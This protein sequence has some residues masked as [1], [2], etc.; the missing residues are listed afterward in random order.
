LCGLLG[1]AL[2]GAYVL[3]VNPQNRNCLRQIRAKTAALERTKNE[4][5]LL[6][7]GDSCVAFGLDP[8]IL[9]E[10]TG[11][12]TIN[13]GFVAGD[14]ALALLGV[15]DQAAHTGD[16]LV[17]SLLPGLLDSNVH[18]EREGRLLA[19]LYGQPSIALGGNPPLRPFGVTEHLLTYL[20]ASVPGARLLVNDASRFALHLPG[21]RYEKCE[22]DEWGYYT[23]KVILPHDP[24]YDEIVPPSPEW[25]AVLRQFVDRMQAR[26]VRVY[27]SMPWHECTA[28]RAA[29]VRRETAAFLTQMGELMPVLREDDLGIKI[30]RSLFADTDFHLRQEGARARSTALGELLNRAEKTA[31]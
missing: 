16:T 6:V 29:L 11:L 25:K 15:A 19:M 12:P 18:P 28:E 13:L 3:W 8:T 5:R 4:A 26:G 9:K 14:G 17:L 21:Y 20:S 30:D 10:A 7:C 24:F 1:L 23:G 2:G 27:F 22:I 31:H